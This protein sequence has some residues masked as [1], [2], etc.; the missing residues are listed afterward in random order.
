ML[1]H[2]VDIN[3]NKEFCNAVFVSCAAVYYDYTKPVLSGNFITSQTLEFHSSLMSQ[4]VNS[5]RVHTQCTF[6]LLMWKSEKSLEIS[7]D[8]DL[9][10]I[11]C[12]LA[13]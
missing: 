11:E 3:E 8:F 5:Y 7:S 12:S 1:V 10:L 4:T 6:T 13:L 2:S 9:T